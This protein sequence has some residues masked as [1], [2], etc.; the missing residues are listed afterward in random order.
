MGVRDGSTFGRKA[1]R[2]WWLLASLLGFLALT[3]LVIVMGLRSTARYQ[4]EQRTAPE[5]V[6]APSPPTI[7]SAGG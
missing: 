2:V 7:K 3:W 5:G 6:H 1:H 4:D